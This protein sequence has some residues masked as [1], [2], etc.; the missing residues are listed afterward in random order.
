MVSDPN[1]RTPTALMPLVD[2][3]EE[4]EAIVTVDILRRAGVRVTLAGVDY[5]LVHSSHDVM[6][7]TDC[8]YSETLDEV[9][10]A[11]VLPGGPGTPKLNF[12]TGLHDRLR[13]QAAA[14]RLVAAICAAPSVLAAAGLL[15]GRRAACYP[16]VEGKLAACGATVEA[17]PVVIDGNIITS[18][19][20]GTTLDFALAV[21]AALAGGPRAGEVA[22]AIVYS[23]G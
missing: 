21:A 22:R 12:V 3:F 9:F 23:P 19:G 1:L 7:Q 14:G 13:A 17:A 18:R 5:R 11:L 2:R 16:S 6:V 15:Q 8:L 20:V 10:D 4:S